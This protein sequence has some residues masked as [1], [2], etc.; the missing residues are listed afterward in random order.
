MS[1]VSSTNDFLRKR[2]G[3][4]VRRVDGAGTGTT[5]PQ[6]RQPVAA[7]R[8]PKPA[9]KKHTKGVAR[10]GLPRATS[11]PGSAVASNF[12]DDYPR[13]FETSETFAHAVRLNLRYEAIFGQNRDIFDGA[14]VL[15]IASHDGRWT[16]AALQTGASKVIGVEARPELVNRARSNLDHYDVSKDR[17]EF[18]TGDVFQVLRDEDIDVDLVLCL[19]FFYHTLRYNE[20]L[21][22]IKATSPAHLIID[23]RIAKLEGPFVRVRT[24]PAIVQG[25]AVAD[26]FNTGERV[27]TGWPTAGAITTMVEAYGFDLAARTD[28]AALLR[29]NPTDESVDIYKT[30]AR[31]TLRYRAAD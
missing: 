2:F 25:N 12:F 28:W 10:I 13:F 27:L 5:P 4:E 19:G 21:H 11:P 23:S 20:L 16:F 6:A 29:D 8:Q 26:E 9:P 1:I 7:E 24:E 22:H 3:V 31:T 15:D 14:T 18:L 30:G 17:Y